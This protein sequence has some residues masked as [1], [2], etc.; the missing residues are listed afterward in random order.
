MEKTRKS[1]PLLLALI[2]F[3]IMIVAMTFVIIVFKG[4][5]HIPILLGAVAAGVIAWLHGYSWKELE[6]YIY[7]GITKVLPAVVILF[8]V[9][10]IISAWIGGGIVTTMIYYGLKIIT[11]SFFLAAMLIICAG[12]TVMIGSSW[13]TI[14]TIGVA[15]MGIGIS[16]GLPPAMIV[17]AIVS[18]AFFGD[19]MSPLSDTTILASGIAGS[20]L[21]QHIKHMLY[22]TVPAFVIALVVYIIMGV[23]FAGMP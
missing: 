4:D 20:T 13:S 19:K 16:M 15:G 7:K 3:L 18:G 14:G 5:P 9:G 10:L 21:S 2:P 11:P 12:V 22:T 17:G 23:K 1:I 6:G 8:M